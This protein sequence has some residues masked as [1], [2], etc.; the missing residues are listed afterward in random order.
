M[1]DIQKLLET[2]IEKT[3]SDLHLTA[4]SPPLLRIDEKLVALDYPALMPEQTKSLAYSV[5]S[6]AQIETFEKTL[7]MD[8]SFGIKNLSRFRVNVYV[9]RGCVGMAVRRIPFQIMSFEEC[10]LPVK[11]V[12]ELSRKP[13]GLILVTGATGSGKSTTLAA[14]IQKINAERRCH[15][16]TIE[17]PIEFTF[18]N[19]LA[20][21][22]QREVGNDTHSFTEALRH[23]LRQD[24]NVILIGEMRD[25]ET[26][27]AA[28]NIAETGHL[29]FATLHTSDCVQT[30]N[31]IIDVFPAHQQQ[32]VRI[33]LS[34]VLQSVLAQ[35]LIP[36][37]DGKGR[38]LATE[39][40]I[41]NHAVRSL[42]REAKTHQIYS[43]IQTAQKEGM[44]TMNMALYDLVM[45]KRILYE[46]AIT[47]TT[48]PDDLQR[49]FVKK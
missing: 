1:V 26:V 36:S 44:R 5:L 7:E 20:V 19:K 4:G 47:R 21:I 42:I 40:M 28:L 32:Q 25:L 13:K 6:P 35:Q 22:E 45:N 14:M 23:V 3:A 9:Q 41:A 11:V 24:P 18:M 10:G 33:Q 29:V 27:Q 12:S 43:V 8:M 38:V 46:E 49:L 17:D 48:E 34:F 31:R 37:A 2:L 30:V 16:I 39:I 15:V